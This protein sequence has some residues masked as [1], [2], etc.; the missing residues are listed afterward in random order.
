MLLD[1]LLTH[2]RREACEG[3]HADLV[4]D[5][6]PG[7]RRPL[8]LQALA[9]EA[10]HLQDAVRH[11]SKLVLPGLEARLAAQDLHHELGAVLRRA[12][13]HGPDHQLELREH[14]LRRGGAP[15]DDVQHADA[16][17]VEPQVLR[18]GLAHAH[19]EAH[20]QEEADGKGVLV[21]A[22]GGV[23]LVGAVH[24]GEELACLHDL[25]DLLPLVLCWVDSS[26]VV[27]AS[28][29]QDHGAL[30]GALERRH[31]AIKVQGL[32]LCL[33]VW[34]SLDCQASLGKDGVVVAPS[35]VRDQDLLHGV[36]H[37][38]LHELGGHA[39]GACA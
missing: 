9:Q 6:V 18:E 38:P 5:V 2:C 34:I 22:A 37:V 36:R 14:C 24:E 19:L 26:G 23:A 12:G 7:A 4:G 32:G 13:V 33:V 39:E 16:L 11:G 10:A 35:G 21:Q 28:M 17:A 1:Q 25:R 3:E 30:C 8:L 27:G 29:E 15:T 20:G 31:H